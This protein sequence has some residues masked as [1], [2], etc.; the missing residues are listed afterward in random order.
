VSE[1]KTEL[2]KDLRDA[3]WA[4]YRNICGA[5]VAIERVLPMRERPGTDEE[6]RRRDGTHS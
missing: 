3:L 6:Q 2:P 4:L 1:P 5:K